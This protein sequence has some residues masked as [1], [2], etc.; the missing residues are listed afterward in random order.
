MC[1]RACPFGA[2]I[3]EPGG[4]DVVK[5]DLCRGN[6]ECVAACPSGALAFQIPT[7]PA[8]R[9]RRKHARDLAEEIEE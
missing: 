9:K 1:I 7:V 4:G 3:Q 8:A 2:M 6:P 5:C